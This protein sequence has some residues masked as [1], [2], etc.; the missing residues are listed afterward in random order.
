[1]DPEGY[2]SGS[3]NSLET[4]GFFEKE[5]ARRVEVFGNIAH[6]FSTYEARRKA[7]DEK[8]FMRGINS[9]QLMN[10]GNRWWVVTI[11]WQGERPDSPIPEKYLK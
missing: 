8:P 7:D 1:M 6:V 2:I 10:D 9:F 3:S 5:I 11:F 4:N